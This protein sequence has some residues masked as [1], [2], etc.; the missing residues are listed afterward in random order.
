[1]TTLTFNKSPVIEYVRTVLY[2]TVRNLTSGFC[3]K[4]QTT[5]VVTLTL[6]ISVSSSVP[7]ANDD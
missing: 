3:R 7:S 4:Q 6:P 2:S 1:M 5:I